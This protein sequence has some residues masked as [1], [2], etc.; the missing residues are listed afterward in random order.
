MTVPKR[1]SWLLSNHKDVRY[2]HIRRSKWGHCSFVSNRPALSAK[3]VGEEYAHIFGSGLASMQ[4]AFC[5]FFTISE[6]L[7]SRDLIKVHHNIAEC[8]YI[9]YTY[10]KD[11]GTYCHMIA[12]FVSELYME[13][14]ETDI[15]PSMADS[16]MTVQLVSIRN[17]IVSYSKQPVDLDFVK[18]AYNNK[19]EGIKNLLENCVTE[20]RKLNKLLFMVGQ[21]RLSYLM[22]Y[23]CG[24]KDFPAIEEFIMEDGVGLLEEQGEKFGLEPGTVQ[25]LFLYTEPYLEYLESLKQL[26]GGEIGC[27]QVLFGQNGYER[28]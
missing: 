7:F 4:Y 17:F 26:E 22:S 21:D 20:C 13:D 27:V 24:G 16:A 8:K 1:T 18:N 9:P 3:T 23:L 12:M 11:D 5:P 2:D 19:D 25:P 6:E 28:G 14:N 15:A 10:L